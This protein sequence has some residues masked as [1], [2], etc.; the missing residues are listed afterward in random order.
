MPLLSVLNIQTPVCY[1][2]LVFG[3]I[4]LCAL[5]EGEGLLHSV[6][7]QQ[8]LDLSLKRQGH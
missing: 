7:G 6:T 3:N 4:S 1:L 2:E 5:C 8:V